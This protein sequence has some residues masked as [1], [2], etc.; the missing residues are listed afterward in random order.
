MLVND[1][2]RLLLDLGSPFLELSSLILGLK[3]GIGLI[4]NT[5]CM[6][7]ANDPKHK[8]GTYMPLTVSKHLRAQEI[9][10]DFKL[11]CVY[12]VDSGGANLPHQADVFPGKNHFGRIFYN[13]ANLSR[14]GIPQIAVVMGSCTAG[15]AYVPAMCD[16][17]IIVQNKGTIFLG[18]PPLVRAATGEVV[19]AETLGGGD[20]HSKHSG[21]TDHLAANLNHS[22]ELAREIIKNLQFKN[23]SV[24]KFKKNKFHDVKNMKKIILSLTDD[25]EFFEFKKEYG[26]TLLCGFSTIFGQKIGILGN[27]GVLFSESALKGAHF[28]QLCNQRQVPLLFLHDVSGFL[29]GS[30]AEKGG[31]AKNGAKLVTAVSC[32]SVRKF[33]L[34]VGKSYGAGNYGMCGRAFSPSL[35]WMW[36]DARIGVMGP[37]QANKVFNSVSSSKQNLVDQFEME[38]R[39]EFASSRLWDDGIM[40]PELTRL[41]LGM[42]LSI[43][44]QKKQPLSFGVFRM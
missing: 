15:G 20:L 39:A 34:I 28:I 44:P 33:S 6:I 43:Q 41:F 4:N 8:A 30:Q 1:R 40:K 7:V 32:A 2:I 14:S 29:V 16:E 9:A 31:I 21:V 10:K 26:K 5:C 11:P 17:S 37:E 42:L 36:P 27:D 19:D 38:S 13:Q 25:S 12:L 3:T 18:G 23:F 35:M 24:K 22:L